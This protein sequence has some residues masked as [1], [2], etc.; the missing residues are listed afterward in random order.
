LEFF[1]SR[2]TVEKVQ[3]TLAAGYFAAIAWMTA[4]PNGEQMEYW[5]KN[6]VTEFTE[7]NNYSNGLNW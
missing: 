6:G 7:Y 5:I 3:A 2:V 4:D 1:N